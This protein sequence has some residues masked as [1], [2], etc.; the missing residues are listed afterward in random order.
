MKIVYIT[1]PYFLDADFPLVRMLVNKGHNVYFFL[2]ICPNALKSPLLNIP[3]IYPFSGIFDSSVYGN[4]IDRY[5]EYLGLDKIF[6]L[7]KLENSLKLK[8]DYA[9]SNIFQRYLDH[10]NPDIIHHISWPSI[11][12]NKWL[13]SY[14]RKVVCTI[15][16]PYPHEGARSFKLRILNIASKIFLKNYILLNNR[17]TDAFKKY[18][19][20]NYANIYY[21]RLGNYELMNLFGEKKKSPE[22]YILF[23]GRITPYKGLDILLPAFRKIQ[24]KYPHIKLIVAGSGKI[25]FDVNLYMNDSQISIRNRFIELEELGTLIKNCKFVVCPYISATQSGV[26]ASV[27]ALNKPLLVTNVGGLPDMIEE[28]KSGIVVPA[29]NVEAL[30]NAIDGLL[31]NEKKLHEMSNFIEQEARNGY[32]SWTEITEDLLDIYN[33]ILS[34]G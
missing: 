18:F 5:K 15:H 28:G 8:E 17:Q 19:C 14:R 16:D 21:S 3:E 29:N 23:F 7:N 26:V 11:D 22:D 13:F 24:E 12:S 4:H 25:H 10:I 34:K 27:L 32:N 33:R 6:I 30:S 9:I 31:A 2:K 1:S 20:I